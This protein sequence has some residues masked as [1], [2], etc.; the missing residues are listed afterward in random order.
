MKHFIVVM[1]ILGMATLCFADITITQKV[2]SGPMMGQPAKNTIQTM[3]IKGNKARIDHQDVAQYQ[4]L[5][6]AA[7]KMYNVDS[8]KK[9]AMV[10]SLDMVNAAGTMFK[11]MNKDAK[12]SVQNTGNTRTVNGFKCT[13][14]IVSLTGGMG[15]TSKQCI[16]KDID[17]TDFEAFR[18]YA[19]GIVKMLVGDNTAKLPQGMAVVT[20]T[21]MTMMGQ[22]IDSKTELQSVKKEEIA[23]SVFEIP[24]GY[25]VK[26]VPGMPKQ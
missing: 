10:M 20:E 9:Q 14:Y 13:D 22:K 5:D 8:E 1:A 26:E 3:Q 4:I 24:A 19:E 18:P 15:M 16:T 25:E 11:Q 17:S 2:E 12:L 7:K 6:L 23:P 21:Q